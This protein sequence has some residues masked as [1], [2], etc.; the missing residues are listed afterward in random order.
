V[1]S[2]ARKIA[3]RAIAGHDNPQRA[4]FSALVCLCD[5]P[6]MAATRTDLWNRVLAV[7]KDFGER[8][9]RKL[10][11]WLAQQR[12]GYMPL[13]DGPSPIMR[14]YDAI[15]A[16]EDECMQAAERLAV[17]KETPCPTN[18]PQN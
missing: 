14:L 10:M 8:D 15:T 7:A 17:P 13:V 4:V 1:S 2:I 3:A 12:R 9:L 11:A 5:E 18:P 6:E 16:L